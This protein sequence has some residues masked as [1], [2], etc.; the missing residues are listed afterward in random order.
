M[1]WLLRHIKN[2]RYRALIIRKSYK[3][4]ADWIDRAKQMY[5]GT[6][7]VFANKP[8]EI[9]FPS[10]AT[11]RTGHLGDPSSYEQYLGQEYQRMVIEEL[12]LI[13]QEDLYEKLLFSC[14]STIPEIKPQV[15]ATTN[16]GGSGHAWVK[17]RFIDI[18]PWGKPYT[19]SSEIEN[20]ATGEK[21]VVKRS[22]VFIHAKVEDNPTLVDNDPGYVLMLDRLKKSNIGLYRAWRFGDWDIPAGQVFSE[23]RYE[24]HVVKPFDIPP[25]WNKWIGYDH[26]VNNPFSVGFYA[27]N[28]DSRVYLVDEIHMNGED[29]QSKY[30]VPFST[31]RLAKLIKGKIKK[32]GWQNYQYMVCDP[33]LWN[34][35]AVGKIKD[36]GVE[37][38]SAAEIMMKVGLK[39]IKGDNDRIN[40]LIRYR[41]VLSKAPDGKPYYQIFQNCKDTIRTIPSLVY[42]IRKGSVEDVDTNGDDHDY[43]RD[44]YF[45]MSRPAKPDKEE[46]AKTELQRYK[47]RLIKGEKRYNQ[48]YIDEYG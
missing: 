27:E 28:H 34:S 20:P 4:L 10:G 11:F 17:R 30:G 22:R 45:F 19:Y 5:R 26:G 14:R 15:F 8:T 25:E 38:E 31:T 3:D 48:K 6:S 33:S 32:M 39:M 18:S 12:T 47:Q 21:T 36:D 35:V 23:F 7:V 13:P 41:E 29:F 24:T 16:P 44:R 2:P 9:R 1:A 42:D 46:Q 37:G 43:D 40:G